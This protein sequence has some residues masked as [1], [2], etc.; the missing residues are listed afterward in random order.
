[1]S[2]NKFLPIGIHAMDGKEKFIKQV[3]EVV[4]SEKKS[5]TW[6][7]I[8]GNVLELYNSFIIVTSSEHQWTTLTFV[9]EKKTENTP[10][11]L[12]DFGSFLDAIKDMEAQLLKK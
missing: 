8:E 10:E 12:I 1:M 11:P 2:H 3:I 7:V 4:D 5:I 6:K 9:Y